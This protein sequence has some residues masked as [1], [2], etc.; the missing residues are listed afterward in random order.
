MKLTLVSYAMC[1]YVHRAAT[2]LREKQAA[3]DVTYIDLK[4]RPPWF[5]KISPRGKVPVLLVDDARP[6]F[7]SMVICELVDE[8]VAPRMLPA[9]PFERARQR[10]W[11]EVANDLFSAHY[12]ISV[13]ANELELAAARGRWDDVVG[14]FEDALAGDFF[15]G[16]ELGLVDVAAAPVFHRVAVVG[17]EKLLLAGFP[18]VAAWGKRLALRPSVV[19][20]VPADFAERFADFLRG[21]G[22]MYLPPGDEARQRAATRPDAP[23]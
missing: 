18:K 21:K 11:F 14:R 3:F 6:V 8:I 17:V 9:D 19:N 7:E 10:A 4:D 2:L 16:D 15:A 12:K 1:P 22:A 20:G 13:A 5:T 23:I